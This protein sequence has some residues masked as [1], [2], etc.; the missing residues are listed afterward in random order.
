MP[1]LTAGSTADGL[2]YYTMPFVDGESLR[3]RMEKGAVSPGEAI[4]T[5]RDVAKALAYAHSRHVVHRDIKPENILLSNGTAVVTDFGIAKAIEVARTQSPDA[6]RADGITRTG[7]SLGTPAY[8]APEQAA[9][10]PN[11]DQR[12]DIYAW[13]VVAYELL[14]GQHPFASKTT[15]Q[16]LMAAHFS[17]MP[18]AL[19]TTSNGVSPMI[20]SLVMRC[21][22]K[23]P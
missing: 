13:G 1:V 9:G 7:T 18:T 2:P 20:A 8:M 5:L 3:A 6:E 21:L 15:P 23:D 17:E 12:A 22:A 11:T 14:A 10:D 16:L 19:V 4:S